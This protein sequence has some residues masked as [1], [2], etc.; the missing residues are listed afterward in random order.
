MGEHSD[1]WNRERRLMRPKMPCLGDVWLVKLDPVVG[2]EQAGTRP[3]VVVSA[4]GLNWSPSNLVIIVPLTTRQ[5]KI[6]FH[7]PVTAAETGLA[8]DSFATCEDVRSV[9]HERLLK[10]IGHVSEEA[11]VEIQYRLRVLLDL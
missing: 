7:V 1:G 2:R 11:R 3:G 10:Q 9:S 6:I 4:D 8:Q 5:H